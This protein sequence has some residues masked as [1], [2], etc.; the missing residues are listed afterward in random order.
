[1]LFNA[2][3]LEFE[4]N[5]L[6]LFKCYIKISVNYLKW[7]ACEYYKLLQANIIY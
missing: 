1:M 4:F 6:V 3:W 7:W 2:I 5:K